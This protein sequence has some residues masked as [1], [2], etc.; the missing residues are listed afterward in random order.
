MDYS[1][2]TDVSSNVQYDHIDLFVSPLCCIYAQGVVTFIEV[3]YAPVPGS[4]CNQ[5]IKNRI[6]TQSKGQ[7]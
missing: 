1:S 7:G 2:Y 6:T 5:R 3:M 4:K